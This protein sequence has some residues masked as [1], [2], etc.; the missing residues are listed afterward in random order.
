MLGTFPK[1]FYQGQERLPKYR[2]PKWQLPKCAISQAATSQMCNF[3]SSNFPKVRLGL[4][5][6]RRLQWENTFEKVPCIVKTWSRSMLFTNNFSTN[7]LW[8]YKFTESFI[9]S[10]IGF[11]ISLTILLWF[12]ATKIQLST[13][14]PYLHTPLLRHLDDTYTSNFL[15][16]YCLLPPSQEQ[17]FQKTPFKHL[18]P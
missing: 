14:P 17:I 9:I 15:P 11:K 5:R 12:S 10:F 18:L 4:L 16:T 8:R 1:V 13:P 7:V 6:P 3:P 2:F